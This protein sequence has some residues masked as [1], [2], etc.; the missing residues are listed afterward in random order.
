MSR[1]IHPTA[2]VEAGAE[3]GADVRIGPYALVGPDVRIGDG[4]EIAGHAILAGRTLIGPCVRVFPF[5][6]VGT[7]PQDLKYQGENSALEI[8]PR[9]V[10]REHAQINVGTVGGGMLTRIGSDCLIMAG[11]HVAHDCRLGD[12]VVLAN[13]VLLGGHCAVEDGAVI[14]GG[15]AV[16]QFVR[17]G[18][19]AMVG[20]LSGVEQ[21][22]LPFTT[23]VGNRARLT[24]L[25]LVG[26]RRR[27]VARETVRNLREAFDLLVASNLTMAERVA[28]LSERF[29]G[30]EAVEALLDFARRPSSRGLCPPVA[31]LAT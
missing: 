8:G 22:V 26:L 14:G 1:T 28:L 11:A 20:G 19:F 3:L 12:N 10:I 16:H 9:T 24:G 18:R 5:A 4:A 2:V 7:E 30:D 6:S 21:D 13:N 29:A 17:I 31:P 25:N 27:A 23:A 15:A